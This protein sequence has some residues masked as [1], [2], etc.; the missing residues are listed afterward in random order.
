[1][2]K[3]I[4]TLKD[5]NKPNFCVSE[6]EIL[7]FLGILVLSGYHRLPQEKHYWSTRPDFGIPIVANA[8]TRNRFQEIKSVIHFADN[9]K[10]VKVIK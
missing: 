4:F 7:T 6:E 1:M 2:S 10:L 5:K 3:L 9:N 8:M